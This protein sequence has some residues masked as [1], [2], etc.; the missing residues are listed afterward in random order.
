MPRLAA[1]WIFAAGVVAAVVLGATAH[2]LRA[3]YAFAA[4]SA[5]AAVLRAVLS[6]PTAGGLV[7]RGRVA[8]VLTLAVLA[9]AVGII[10]QTMN[11]HPHV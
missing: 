6:P 8:D 10:G 1:W 7:V 3:T 9:A 2:P 5:V 11:L 4:A